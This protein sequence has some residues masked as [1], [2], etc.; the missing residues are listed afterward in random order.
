[1]HINGQGIGLAGQEEYVIIKNGYISCCIDVGS[2]EFSFKQN[3]H[4]LSVFIA[5]NQLFVNL[6]AASNLVYFYIGKLG[7]ANL[8]KLIACTWGNSLEEE[9]LALLGA[10][11]SEVEWYTPYYQSIESLGITSLDEASAY[12]IGRA[13]CR[14]RVLRLV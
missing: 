2:F 1:M 7:Q 10:D 13:S 11:G 12:E 3:L 14:E 8:A 9:A 5:D 6:T 4:K